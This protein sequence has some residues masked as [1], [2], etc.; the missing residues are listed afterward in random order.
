[1][2]VGVALRAS[3]IFWRKVRAGKEGMI[4]EIIAWDGNLGSYG[5]VGS[6][7]GGEGVIISPLR[8]SGRI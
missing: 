4:C 7:G 8:G 5:R 2:I 1:M 6:F 3:I